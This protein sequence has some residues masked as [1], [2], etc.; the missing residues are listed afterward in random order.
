MAN[1]LPGSKPGDGDYERYWMWGDMQVVRYAFGNMTVR[2][3]NQPL[4]PFVEDST[5]GVVP[6][7]RFLPKYSAMSDAE[8]AEQRVWRHGGYLQ[9]QK[10]G[11]GFREEWWDVSRVAPLAAV[12]VVVAHKAGMECQLARWRPG[13]RR[14][15]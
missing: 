10:L 11:E 3:P 8:F 6:G 12:V 7:L 14:R 4:W 1:P 2:S 5:H 15:R 13:Q 9:G